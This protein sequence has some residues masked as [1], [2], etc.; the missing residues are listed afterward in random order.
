MPRANTSDTTGRWRSA[1]AVYL[2]RPV[3]VVLLLGFSAGLPLALS[4]ATL[5]VWL[6]DR[7]VG[8]ASIGLLSLASYREIIAASLARRS[9]WHNLLGNAEGIPWLAG[10]MFHIGAMN[11]DPDLRVPGALSPALVL[12]LV[13]IAVVVV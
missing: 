3:L 6:A 5:T 9:S 1:L 10:Q 12:R 13:V 4:G 8:L 2:S 11:A 7:G